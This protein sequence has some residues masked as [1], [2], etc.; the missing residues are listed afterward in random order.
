M[1]LNH[2]TLAP[3]YMKIRTIK[4][5]IVRLRK[6]TSG[7]IL[8]DCNSLAFTTGSLRCFWAFVGFW[9]AR[10]KAPVVQARKLFKN[11]PLNCQISFI[12]TTKTAKILHH[13]K[14]NGF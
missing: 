1:L 8:K 7:L 13:N 6:Q 3:Q 10:E 4:V 11:R 14:M 9:G 2:S 5:N 12:Y